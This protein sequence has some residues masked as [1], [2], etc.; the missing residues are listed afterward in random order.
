MSEELNDLYIPQEGDIIVEEDTIN[1]FDLKLVFRDNEFLVVTNDTITY[2]LAD[3]DENVWTDDSANHFYYGYIS[4]IE[5]FD[6]HLKG[7]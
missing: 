4:C 7:E 1:E 3:E 2:Y 6:I 5:T